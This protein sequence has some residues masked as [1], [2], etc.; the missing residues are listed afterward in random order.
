VFTIA[1]IL[2]NA[3]IHY[4]A[5]DPVDYAMRMADP[6]LWP[7]TN[8]TSLFVHADGEHLWGNMLF[9]LVFVGLPIAHSTGPLGRPVR[10]LCA[11]SIFHRAVRRLEASV[12]GGQA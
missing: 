5:I 2:A 10:D 9:L 4:S 11:S 1:L 7:W 6:S 8:F 12:T 3:A